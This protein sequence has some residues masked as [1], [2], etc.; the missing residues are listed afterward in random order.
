MWLAAR[1]LSASSALA[2]C[3]S[4]CRVRK[5][6]PIWL[7]LGILCLISFH[8]NRSYLEMPLDTFLFR[9]SLLPPFLWTY[10]L[11]DGFHI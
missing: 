2:R 10:L 8:R 7:H 3:A 1:V 9:S 4:A 11:C 6:G 5:R